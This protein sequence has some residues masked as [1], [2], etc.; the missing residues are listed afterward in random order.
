[1]RLG[2]DFG[3]AE[4]VAEVDA[5]PRGAQIAAFFDF[6][7]T[8]I[9]GYS[10]LLFAQDRIRRGRVG[11]SEFVRSAK[12]GIE[13]ALGKAGH[14]ELIEL[15]GATWKGDT[16]AEVE[17]VAERVYRDFIADRIYPE[18]RALVA[19]HRRRGH[20]VAITTSATSFQ[21]APIAR[22]LGIDDVVC[23]HLEIRD[24]RVTGRQEGASMWGPGKAAAALDFADARG[25]DFGASWFYADGDEDAALMREIGNP[26]P[27]NPG[28]RLDAEAEAEGWPVLRFRS[29]G[30]PSLDVLARNLGGLIVAAPIASSAAAVGLWHRSRR[31]AANAAT[32][33]VPDVVLGLTAVRV[34][35]SGVERLDAARPAVVV[36]NQRSRID[37][38]V[39]AK[40]LRHDC[41]LVVDRALAGDPVIGTLGRLFDIEFVRGVD[42]L[43]AR[44]QARY[45]ERLGE[46]TSIAF[47]VGDPDRPD[48]IG[49]VRSAPLRLAAEAGVPLVPVVIHDSERLVTRRPP[50]VRPGTIT[51]DVLEARHPSEGTRASLDAIA[52]DTTAA[53][54]TALDA[55]A[56]VIDLTR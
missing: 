21:V 27:T 42:I 26:R 11:A 7:G 4:A 16:I 38:F 17:A 44:R 34:A 48:V 28:R 9:H 22:I 36:C 6:D 43:D 18:A 3:I 32:T 41:T 8:L 12:V 46:G 35:A 50:V 15:A 31:S 40:L 23:Q 54:Q 14:A 5:S 37:T 56:G 45:L 52:R 30:T 33:L 2:P 1:M 53:M 24:G 51:L 55:R 47:L 10:A 13:Y 19:A 29:R 49:P 20:T 39:L 25:I